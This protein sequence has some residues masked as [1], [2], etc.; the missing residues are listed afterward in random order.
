MD[1]AEIIFQI[2]FMEN[3]VNKEV[4]TLQIHRVQAKSIF[5]GKHQVELICKGYE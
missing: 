3:P 4:G 2:T 5:Y 1:P